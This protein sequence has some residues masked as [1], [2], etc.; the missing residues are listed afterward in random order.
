MNIK[1]AIF[2][3]DG[4]LVDSLMFWDHLW[5]EIGKRYLNDASFRPDES[6]DKNVRTMIYGD[7]MAY[8]REYYNISEDTD[9]FMSFATEA[10]ADFYRQCVKY[11]TGA[12][13]LLEYLKG[14]GMPICLA[15][16]TAMKDIKVALASC[17][18]EKYFD[19][20]LSCDDIGA[21][22]DRPDIYLLAKERLGLDAKDICVF[23]DSCVALETAKSVGFQTVGVFDKY[24]F[25][26]DRLEAA[27]DI[28]LKEGQPL[29]MLID[30]INAVS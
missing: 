20:V 30:H 22:K 4:T 18:L 29:D 13:E 24:N 14:S 17:G 16:A 25:G 6:V 12:I 11:K 27:S 5:G 10:L 8:V 23:E 1:G 19:H 3:M 15:S 7:A 9:A 28:Y 26:Q 21:G 2:D